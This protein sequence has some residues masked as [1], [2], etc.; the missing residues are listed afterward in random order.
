MQIPN[1]CESNKSLV[2]QLHNETL[3]DHKEIDGLRLNDRTKHQ[4]YMLRVSHACHHF[5]RRCI[6]CPF[7]HLATLED[8][9][10]AVLII[11]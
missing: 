7:L 10:M 6:C 8:L 4:W 2:L 3:P 5:Q 9:P 11:V 1:Y